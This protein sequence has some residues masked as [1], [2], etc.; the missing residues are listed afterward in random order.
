MQLAQSKP[1]ELLALREDVLSLRQM[2]RSEFDIPDPYPLPLNQAQ[3]QDGALAALAVRDLCEMA[4]CA[5]P[6]VEVLAR[7]VALICMLAASRLEKLAAA[8]NVELA[9]SALTVREKIVVAAGFIADLD[10][11]TRLR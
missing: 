5:T 1:A 4:Q 9:R 6:G 8:A 11:L 10:P 7:D 3:D 2:M